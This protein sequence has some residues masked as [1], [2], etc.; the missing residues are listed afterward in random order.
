MEMTNGES[1]GRFP[2]VRQKSVVLEWRHELSSLKTQK[3]FLAYGQGR[4]YGDVCLNDG[5]VI[6]ETSS[7]RRFILFDEDTGL[8]RAEAGVTLDQ[9]LRLVVPRGW[10]LPVTPGTKFVSLGGA[11][12]NDVHGKNHHLH[13]TFGCH[14]RAFELARSDGPKKRCSPTENP[15]WFAATIGGLGLTGLITWVEIQLIPIVS[16][17]IDITSTRFG[18]LAEFFALSATD[19][20]S[21]VYTVAWLDCLAKGAA[22]G[23][24]LFLQGNHSTTPGQ[25]RSG[26]ERQ[27]LTPKVPFDFPEWA[28]SPLSIRAFNEVYYRKQRHEIV[29]FTG[30]YDPFFYPLDGVSE[31][32]RMYGKR[33]FFQFQCVVPPGTQQ[34]VTHELLSEVARTRAASFLAVMKEFGDIAS[35]GILSFPRPGTTI[36]LDFAN[37]GQSTSTLLKRLERMVRSAGGA[38]YPAKDALMDRETFERSFPRWKEIVA[39]RDPSIS[40]SFWRRVTGE[41]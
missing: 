13:G 25:K 29:R 37:R 9:V 41:G 6:L 24:G 21:H 20:T 31:W 38:L 22:L 11:V 39:Y 15:E 26:H 10:F 33:G 28:L 40:S 34:D 36:C 23:R 12:A 1:W 8:L 3:H 35:P 7:L 2:K 30:H 16:D 18:N 27:R 32:N 4:S 17:Q 19:T 5:G 14:V